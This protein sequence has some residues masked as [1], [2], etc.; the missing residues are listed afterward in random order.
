MSRLTAAA[1]LEKIRAAKLKLEKEEQRLMSRTHDKVLAQIVQLAHSA[2]LTA[3]EITAALGSK[4]KTAGKP[5]TKAAKTPKV[6]RSTAGKKVAPKYR[7]PA[8]PEQSW[9]GRGR[10]PLWVQE[11]QNAGQLASA[12]IKPAI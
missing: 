7:N 10:T 4:G 12:E 6:K 5:G 9:T 8:N 3:A 11:L 1:Q 2:G